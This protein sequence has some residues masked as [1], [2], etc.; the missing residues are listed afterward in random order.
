[1]FDLTQISD[2]VKVV[3]GLA[4]FATPAGIAWR[5]MR[6]ATKTLQALPGIQATLVSIQAN[7]GQNGGASFR[8]AVDRIETAVAHISATQLVLTDGFEQPIIFADH[9]GDCVYV[10]AA[11]KDMV[12]Y[13]REE[14][15]GRGWIAALQEGCR[16]RVVETWQRAVKDRRIFSV[17]AVFQHREGYHIHVT[18]TANTI[19]GGKNRGVSGWLAVA[20][21]QK[22]SHLQAGREPR[23]MFP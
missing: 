4:A 8:D 15:R 20:R 13:G 10:N 7:L 21:I 2:T 9:H 17:E 6:K 14:M 23:V 11:F 22:A 16:D 19:E 3:A 1:M 18:M 5:G 12:G